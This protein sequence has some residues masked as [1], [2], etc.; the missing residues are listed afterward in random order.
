MSKDYDIVITKPNIADF[1]Y[2]EFEKYSS[3]LADEFINGNYVENIYT[4]CEVLTM[5]L[6]AHTKFLQCYEW[7]F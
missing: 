3:R 6:H 1:F 2:D 4:H 5:V 7:S